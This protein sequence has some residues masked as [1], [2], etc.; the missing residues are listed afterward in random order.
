MNR[1]KIAVLAEDDPFRRHADVWLNT[2][3]HDSHVPFQI[4]NY[5]TGESLLA[6]LYSGMQFD[7]L[8][9]DFDSVKEKV[10][11][12]IRLFDSDL[13][14]IC[15]SN[16]YDKLSVAFELGAFHYLIR[17]VD[18]KMFAGILKRAVKRCFEKRDRFTIEWK[19]QVE[20]IS[21]KNIICV[22]GF[23]RHIQIQTTSGQRESC[24]PFKEIVQ[25]LTAAG[26]IRVHQSFL[27]NPSHIK[28]MDQNEILCTNGIAVPVSI[29]R[30]KEVLEKFRIYIS[31]FSI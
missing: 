22:E 21:L 20:V 17:P 27:V 16:L 24:Q 3:F 15:I 23:N 7:I 19:H 13:L 10:L 28:T 18:F 9:L 6:Q 25:R 4:S 5:K 2:F 29:R 11:K 14:M 12:Q 1:V 8:L 30:K 26:F 31:N